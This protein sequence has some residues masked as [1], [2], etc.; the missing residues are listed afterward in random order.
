MPSLVILNAHLC[1]GLKVIQDTVTNNNV[2]ITTNVVRKYI[3][4][5]NVVSIYSK[6][7]F[8]YIFPELT[9][10][11][12]FIKQNLEWIIKHYEVLF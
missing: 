10:S 3:V 1:T 8:C 7:V 6:K 11:G 9:F 4:I 2:V 12:I 5:N